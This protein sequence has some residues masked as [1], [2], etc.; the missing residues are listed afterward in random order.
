MSLSHAILPPALFAVSSTAFFIAIHQPYRRRLVLSPLLFGSSALSLHSS[1]FLAYLGG[2]NVLWALFICVWIIHA[3][4]VLYFDQLTLPRTASSWITTYKAWNDPCRRT[5]WEALSTGNRRAVCTSRAKFMATR[6]S[7]L[8]ACWL[9]QLCIVGPAVPIYFQ[10]NA[11]DFAPSRQVIVRRLL[12]SGNAVTCREVQIRVFVS[13]YWIWM[14]FLMLDA[15]N[16]L[17]SFFFVL[18]LRID[19]PEDWPPLF[20]DPAE[21]YSVRRFW[22]KFWHGL[23]VHS[24]AS[25]GRLIA[26]QRL[27]MIPGSRREK[28]FLAFWTFLLSGICHAIANWQAGE[29][30]IPMTDIL[31]FSAN[32]GAGAAEL[33]VVAWVDRALQTYGAHGL[34]RLLWS[35]LARRTIGFAWLL[36]FFFWIT[37]KWQYPTLRAVLTPVHVGS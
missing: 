6:L 3:A 33:F 12:L 28:S 9:L 1:S 23:T 32:F 13:V 26:R 36:G 29:P 4:A 27:R 11:Q 37:P 20:G 18:V 22:S 34:R 19:T 15:C 21:A 2:M 14:A 10:F 35:R 16:V 25:S 30:G 7:K 24:C 8:V 17:L 5:D 31:F